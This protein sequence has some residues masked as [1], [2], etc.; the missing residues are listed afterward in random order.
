M[1]QELVP[2]P[3]Y[4]L[5]ILLFRVFPHLLD[6]LICTRNAMSI[7]LLIQMMVAI[8]FWVMNDLYC[9]VGLNLQ[10]FF[11]FMH[12][13]FILSHPQ[14]LFLSEQT[15]MATVFVSLFFLR[16]LC[17]SSFFLGVTCAQKLLCLMCKAIS[18]VSYRTI[19]LWIA[20]EK[21]E[22]FYFNHTLR[23]LHYSIRHK[24]TPRSTLS[25]QLADLLFLFII[26]I[27]VPGVASA[28]IFITNKKE[29][30]FNLSLLPL[31][32]SLCTPI[33]T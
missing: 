1:T 10:F 14:C 28:K 15:M 32:V 22:R 31:S 30:V 11:F 24:Q 6:C 19:V 27:D 12:L 13:F 2:D 9:K 4:K 25:F 23:C 3:E 5:N 29:P 16:F 21:G 7:V 20:L 18:K 33:S 8:D 17:L 26:V